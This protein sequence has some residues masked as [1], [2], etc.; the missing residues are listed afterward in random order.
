MPPVKPFVSD[1]AN[2]K[3]VLSVERASAHGKWRTSFVPY[4]KGMMDAVCEKGVQHVSFMTSAQM[5]KTEG[6][7]NILLWIMLYIGGPIMFLHPTISVARLW[8][9]NW[10]S[11]AIRDNDCIN[12]L[13]HDKLVSDKSDEILHKKFDGGHIIIGGTNSPAGL[14]AQPIGNLLVDEVDRCPRE[15]GDEGDPIDLAIKR[16]TGYPGYLI[17]LASTPTIK[18]DSRIETAFFESDQR[19]YF[20]PCPDCGKFQI[21]RWSRVKWDEGDTST[22]KYYCKFCDKGIPHY[23][24]AKM[25]KD[26][27]WRATAESKGKVG[28]WINEVYSSFRSWEQIA[29]Q[30][31]EVKD[32]PIRHKSF[33]NTVLGETY[34][35]IVDA[36]DPDML[37]ERAEEYPELPEGV[38]VITAGVDV[39]MRNLTVE[40]AGWGKDNESWSLAADVIFG[41]TLQPA[42]WDKLAKYLARSFGNLKIRATAIDAAYRPDQVSLF[43]RKTPRVY[44]VRGAGGQ[45]GGA[46]RWDA[47]TISAK[48]SKMEKSGTALRI[49]G[50]NQV[51]LT[52]QGSFRVEEPGPSY[53]HFPE[54]RD[55]EWF[56]QMASE[57]IKK[58]INKNGFPQKQWDLKK[59]T[60]N[61]F[62]DCRVYAMAALAICGPDINTLIEVCARERRAPE[63]SSTPRGGGYL[64]L[65]GSG[66]K[67]VS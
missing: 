2:E 8:S 67:W 23:K 3:R 10:L 51:K 1:W 9:K 56:T 58:V 15:A 41:D 50:T 19:F 57:V 18:G 39:H 27:E 16:T 4:L 26:G 11:T 65:R 46:R 7:G 48:T 61:H 52:I 47:P 54:G 38:G 32:N 20:V 30:Y 53:C 40:V 13:F 36:V 42:V 6:M 21:L 17:I 29:A 43:V 63:P 22:A 14:C 34:E 25:I 60:H 49:V 55:E 12:A 64:G 45:D 66:E 24:K 62:L 35:E 31:L 37:R 28:F 33:V 44:A 59:N 5:A